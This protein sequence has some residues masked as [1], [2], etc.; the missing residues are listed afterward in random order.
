MSTGALLTAVEPGSPAAAVGLAAGDIVVG[1]NGRA[2]D[3]GH[4]LV[5]LLKP[6]PAAG[7]AELLILR[8]G[9]EIVVTVPL[10]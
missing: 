8:D 6:L 3:S 7:S 9:R 10:A 2:I 1:V 5:N 4:P